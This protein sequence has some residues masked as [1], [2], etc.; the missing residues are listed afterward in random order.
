[1]TNEIPVVPPGTTLPPAPAEALD[2]ITFDNEP[3][4]VPEQKVSP[5]T[6]PTA[7]VTETPPAKVEVPV[8]KPEPTLPSRFEG[9]SD[10]Q[11][12]L[13]TRLFVT[14]QAKA[15]AES[16]EEKSLL[17]QEMKK[18]RGE[19]AQVNQ[20][21]QDAPPA[22]Q[23]PPTQPNE[24]EVAIKTVK[25]LGF[26]TADE[27]ALDVERIVNERLQQQ[28]IQARQAEQTTAIT[29]FYKYRDDIYTDES[30]RATLENYVL[31]MF[32][33]Q[34]PTMTKPQLLQA[35]EMSANYLYPRGTASKLADTAQAKT[36]LLNIHGSQ[37]GDT[38][39]ASVSDSSKTKLREMG[40]SE[41]DIVSF[42][43]S[44]K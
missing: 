39:V 5:E 32:K 4:V 36:D 21:K 6:P 33:P 40:W 34:L 43:K 30:K 41:A 18:I 37:G 12:D 14:G 42:E 24:R 28:N 26:K 35:L 23:T 38:A 11:Y 13:R 7:A 1:M 16:P 22:S 19:I 20:V 44:G 2:G 17:A 29:D 10:T 9:E 27:V 25:D 31:E 8:V 3:S 15:N